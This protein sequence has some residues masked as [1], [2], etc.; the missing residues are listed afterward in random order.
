MKTNK[1]QSGFSIIVILIIIA[2][3]GVVGF[4][5]Y[6]AYDSTQSKVIESDEAAVLQPAVAS[7]VPAAIEVTTTAS[8]DEA[9]AQLDGINLEDDA[10][11]VL[12]DSEVN[13]F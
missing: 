8:L 5:G 12:L 2:V 1:L 10:D 3:I 7:D 13:K 11:I 9:T 4:L 6:K